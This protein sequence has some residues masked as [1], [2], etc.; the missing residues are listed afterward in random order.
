MRL[1]SDLLDLLPPLRPSDLLS[2][3]L[4]LLS[5]LL[6]TLL[7]LLSVLLDRLTL[8]PSDPLPPWLGLAGGMSPMLAWLTLPLLFL[9]MLTMLC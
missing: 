8:E 9:F 3:L 1:L 4:D 2:T 5:D 6:S 7:D